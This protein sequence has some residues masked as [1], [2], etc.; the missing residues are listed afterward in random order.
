MDNYENFKLQN[1]FAKNGW[2]CADG[3]PPGGHCRNAMEGG[4]G[5]V[6]CGQAPAK[7]GKAHRPS[8]PETGQTSQG[9]FGRRQDGSGRSPGETPQVR[10]ARHDQ[11][12]SQATSQTQGATGRQGDRRPKEKSGASPQASLGSNRA[13][14]RA[15]NRATA[16]R[17]P[18]RFQRRC[19]SGGEVTDNS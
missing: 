3:P 5:A 17:C 12:T 9:G 7:T 1:R 11:E 15:A 6:A 18:G 13:G 2:P 19:L 4:Q 8:R 10:P 16:R 14:P